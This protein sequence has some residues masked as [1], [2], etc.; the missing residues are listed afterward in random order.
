MS[1]VSIARKRLESSIEGG[2][3][4]V[5]LLPEKNTLAQWH[6]SGTVTELEKLTPNSQLARDLA[7]K[8][9]M[10]AVEVE[11]IARECGKI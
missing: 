11:P 2:Q 3:V 6:K 4:L 8:V 5:L 9:L 10:A 7:A 1:E